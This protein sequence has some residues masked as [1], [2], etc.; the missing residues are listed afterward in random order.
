MRDEDTQGRRFLS[1]HPCLFPAEEFFWIP[2]ADYAL[3]AQT[4]YRMLRVSGLLSGNVGLRLLYLLSA[5]FGCWTLAAAPFPAPPPWQP[6]PIQR[7]HLRRS[8]TLLSSSTPADRKTVRIL[9]Y[10][11][12]ITQQAWWTEVERYLRDT[13]TNANL[14]IENRAIGGHS[15]QLLVKTAEADLYSFQPD[16]L[17]F[18]VYGSHL[19][20]ESIIRRVRERTCAD[21]L[22][23]T[24]HLTKD[25]S[26]TEETDP[27][28]LSPQQW[29]PWMNHV[30]LP[31][32]AAKYG[33]CRVD[34]HE[35]WK[36][37]LKA[38]QLKA[39]NL[40]NDGVHLNAHGEWLMAE[41][42]K[43]Y[44]APLAPKPGYDPYNEPWVR[45]LAV[46]GAPGSKS[47]QLAFN[48]TR[49]D[50]LFKPATE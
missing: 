18:H 35:L 5:L 30:F 3:I 14:I 21:I 39:S 42:L 4:E 46:S 28:K 40:L 37:Y 16:L 36:T 15:S 27:A 10:G 26:L 13:Y 9:F 43:P 23:Q 32:T 29:D 2:I 12:S 11:Q 25:E 34:I 20:Y 44:L 6:D 50:L 48:G 19:D 1:R 49:V 31:T 41:L 33:A 22:L 24:D 8:L 38:H 47:V 7:E 45:T 17:I